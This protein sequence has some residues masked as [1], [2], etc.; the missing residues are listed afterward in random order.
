MAR[1]NDIGRVR[2]RT[3]PFSSPSHAGRIRPSHSNADLPALVRRELAHQRRA[4]WVLFLRS[5][6]LGALVVGVVG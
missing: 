5:L 6:A 4:P 1:D 2:C 3:L